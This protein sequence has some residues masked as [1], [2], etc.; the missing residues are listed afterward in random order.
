M[1]P[2][3]VVLPASAAVIGLAVLALA[4]G[5]HAH[6]QGD[7]ESSAP[8][9]SAK[10]FRLVGVVRGT[11]ASRHVA[12]IAVDGYP[13]YVAKVGDGL[14][15]GWT[16]TRIDS[17]TAQLARHAG[18]RVLLKLGEASRREVRAPGEFRQSPVGAASSS[19]PATGA[20]IRN[21]GSGQSAGEPDPAPID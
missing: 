7:R 9:S 2:V 20:G 16:L 11:D 8:A 15:G 19:M 18:E 10:P 5:R 3:T 17:E 13:A 12:L 14:G 6:A 21:P 4:G 1:N